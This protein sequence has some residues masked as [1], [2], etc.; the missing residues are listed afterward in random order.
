MRFVVFGMGLLLLSS[1]PI[2]AAEQQPQPTD[3]MSSSRAPDPKPSTG[4]STFDAPDKPP[5]PWGEIPGGG[6]PSGY[7][8][9]AGQKAPQYEGEKFKSAQQSERD[10]IEKPGGRD[11]R[12]PSGERQGAQHSPSSSTQSSSSSSQSSE[13]VAKEG[14]GREQ[15]HQMV[16]PEHLG[17]QGGSTADSGKAKHDERARAEQEAGQSTGTY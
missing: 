5:G 11:A 16:S 15:H 17:P 14:A 7:N 3:P 13:D 10:A 12:V 8:D 9:G 6:G 1:A 2:L 4:H